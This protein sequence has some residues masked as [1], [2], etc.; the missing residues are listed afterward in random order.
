MGVS[1]LPRLWG[2]DDD[3]VECPTQETTTFME[4]RVPFEV[5]DR[6]GGLDQRV[7]LHYIQP[8]YCILPWVSSFG[9]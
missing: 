3:F 2:R 9:T 7:R 1:L 8:E 5:W 4:I 6:I